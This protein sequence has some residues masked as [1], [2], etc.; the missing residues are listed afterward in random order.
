LVIK[1]YTWA[2]FRSAAQPV[3]SGRIRSQQQRESI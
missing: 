1:N 2:D 3:D